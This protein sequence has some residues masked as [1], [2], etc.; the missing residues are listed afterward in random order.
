MTDKEIEELAE[1]EA[2]KKAKAGK[3][4]FK[5]FP[6][7]RGCCLAFGLMTM[8][9]GAEL[10]FSLIV[11]GALFSIY[12]YAFLPWFYGVKEGQFETA[13]AEAIKRLKNERSINNRYKNNGRY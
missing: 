9:C 7:F 2:Y 6:F 1:K 10:G 5:F 13:K 12:S 8:V 3:L 11:M 4:F